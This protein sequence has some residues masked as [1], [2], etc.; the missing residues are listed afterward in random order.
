MM[1]PILADAWDLIKPNEMFTFLAIVA[2]LLGIGVGVKVIFFNKSNTLISP[3]PLSIALEKEFETKTDAAKTHETLQRDTSDVESYAHTEVRAILEMIKAGEMEARLR[4]ER[5]SAIEA[6]SKTHTRLL[7]GL[8]LK[9][10]RVVERVGDKV[11]SI[12]KRELK[13]GCP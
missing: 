8:T 7:E 10:D 1:N 11:E 12:L 13:N 5:L 3:Q 2:V 9:V 6:D 4:S